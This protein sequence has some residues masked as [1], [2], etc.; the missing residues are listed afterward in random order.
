MHCTHFWKRYDFE[1]LRFLRFSMEKLFFE[2]YNCAGS[3]HV[4]C[5]YIFSS[6]FQETFHWSTT[7][8][9]NSESIE[10]LN[11]FGRKL[12]FIK[13]TATSY[14]EVCLFSVNAVAFFFS[15]CKQW[16]IMQIRHHSISTDVDIKN[17]V[18]ICI[19]LHSVA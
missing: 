9:S 8:L 4:K 3:Y 2:R 18:G 16:A 7:F 12:H 11:K 15:K 17:L 13:K 5:I 19:E 14:V 6:I 1:L 10:L